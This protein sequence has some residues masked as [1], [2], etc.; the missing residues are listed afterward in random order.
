MIVVLNISGVHFCGL[1]H[2]RG[3]CLWLL[4]YQGCTFVVLNISGVHVCG[5]K[6]IRGAR[7]RS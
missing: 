1:K 7:L 3:A 5:F 2:I 6:H 4:A